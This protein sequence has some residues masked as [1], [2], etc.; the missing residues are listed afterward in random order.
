VE[1]TG[2][3]DGVSGESTRDCS[4]AEPCLI[5]HNGAKLQYNATDYYGST[6]SDRALWFRVDP[7]GVANASTT[8]DGK[9]IGLFIYYD[10]RVRSTGTLIPGT[11]N[12]SASY[13]ADT[14]KDP[15]W[16]SWNNS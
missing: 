4:G 9:A 1:T 7:D 5:L 11:G 2:K 14:S 10:G 13:T 15:S 16:F 6:D 8:A 12:A 3:I